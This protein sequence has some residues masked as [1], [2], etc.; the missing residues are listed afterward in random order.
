[1][2]GI[3]NQAIQG[4]ITDK[5]GIDKWNEIKERSS[6]NVD[7]FISNEPYNDSLTYDIV[8]VA[9]EVLKIDATIILEEF[10][11][12]W[13]T[14][15]GMEKYGDLMKSGG[16]NFTHFVLNLPNFHSRVMLIFPNLAPPEFSVEQVNEQLLILH[17]YSHRD[18]LSHFVL[19]I[20]KGIGQIYNTEIETKIILSEKNEF[21]HD[22]I[23]IN[24]IN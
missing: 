1:M 20:I 12:Y 16:K 2:Y 15:I 4:L 22:I 21:Q 13:A 11:F 9:S 10:G 19:G 8:G 5:F 24:I 6:V 7:Y 18:G 3:V 23:E 17:Y 14:V